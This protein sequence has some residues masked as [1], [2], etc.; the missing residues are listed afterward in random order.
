MEIKIAASH[1]EYLKVLLLANE[2]RV[3]NKPNLIIATITYITKS[4][5]RIRA[6]TLLYHCNRWQCAHTYGVYCGSDNDDFVGKHKHKHSCNY[7]LQTSGFL[8]SSLTSHSIPRL[9][10][11]LLLSFLLFCMLGE[12]T[13]L[14]FISPSLLCA[15]QT[16]YIFCV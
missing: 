2:R 10:F 12:W 4:F 16:I 11:L 15:F 7:L 8:F 5:N 13:F 14:R 6:I 1:W 9:V 3:W